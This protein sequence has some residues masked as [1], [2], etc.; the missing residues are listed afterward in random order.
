MVRLMVIGGFKYMRSHFFIH[1][2]DKKHLFN[3]NYIH[4]LYL[5]NLLTIECFGT[6]AILTGV[7]CSEDV[8]LEYG[9]CAMCVLLICCFYD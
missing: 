1:K 2:C 8:Q 3:F 6:E 9:S 5:S 4:S 7:K